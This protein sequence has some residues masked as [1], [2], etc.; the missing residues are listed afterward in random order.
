MGP[1][2]GGVGVNFLVRAN[3]T[4]RN[5]RPTR[6]KGPDESQNKQELRTGAANCEL[7]TAT[8][9]MPLFRLP[10]KLH[11]LVD[12]SLLRNDQ[13]AHAPAC[14]P[15][16]RLPTGGLFAPSVVWARAVDFVDKPIP[17]LVTNSAA[18]YFATSRGNANI[19]LPRL[20]AKKAPEKGATRR[21]HHLKLKMQMHSD[22]RA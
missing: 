5:S 15:Q 9:I 6:D 20:V 16:P 12:G 2:S 10:H 22:H 18:V 1:L 17:R 7:R 8:T 11:R 14:R 19:L 4:F 3:P 21:T 13:P